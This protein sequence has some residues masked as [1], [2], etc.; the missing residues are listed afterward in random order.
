MKLKFKYLLILFVTFVSSIGWTSQDSTHQIDYTHDLVIVKNDND[1][2]PLKS[3][4]TLNIATLNLSNNSSNYFENTLDFYT[5][6]SH[7][8][9]NTFSSKRIMKVMKKEMNDYNIILINTDTIHENM[10]N[11]ISSLSGNKKLIVNYY[12]QQKLPFYDLI[13]SKVSALLYSPNT[14]QK[15]ISIGCQIIFGV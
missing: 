13:E 14:N 2:I 8:H 4:D 6:S 11:F 12:G 9:F 10:A 7:Y 15:D 3:L 5:Q 1:L